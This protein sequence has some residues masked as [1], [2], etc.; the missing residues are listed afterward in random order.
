[1]TIN[2]HYIYIYIYPI[3][4]LDN[5]MKLWGIVVAKRC[6]LKT[7]LRRINTLPYSMTITLKCVKGSNDLGW[8]EKLLSQAE[9]EILIKAV[10]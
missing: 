3:K 1:M 7:Y 5:Y 9:R 8:E 10:V 2:K 6:H 4:K